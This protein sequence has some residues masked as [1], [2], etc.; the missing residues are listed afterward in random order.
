MTKLL[1]DLE[2]SAKVY[3]ANQKLFK[4]LT[5][6]EALLGQSVDTLQ[7]K[8]RYNPELLTQEERETLRRLNGLA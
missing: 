2:F 5:A 4:E 1:S 6:E 8:L 7:W 3:Q